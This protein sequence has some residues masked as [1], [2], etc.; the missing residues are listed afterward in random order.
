MVATVGGAREDRGTRGVVLAA[1]ALAVG[2]AASS[3][4]TFALLGR[5]SDFL[6]QWGGASQAVLLICAV[7]VIGDGLGMR[8]RPQIRVQVPERWRRAMPLP[9][10]SLL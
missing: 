5:L 9:I 7:A 10:A 1:L 8:V 4:A 2:L 6:P 3:A